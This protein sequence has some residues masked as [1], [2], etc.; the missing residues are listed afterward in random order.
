[1]SIEKAPE[2]VSHAA[3]AREIWFWGPE[4]RRPVMG[5]KKEAAAVVIC[6]MIVGYGPR[7]IRDVRRVTRWL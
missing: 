4:T 3:E 5:C 2:R 1:M 6:S 7:G